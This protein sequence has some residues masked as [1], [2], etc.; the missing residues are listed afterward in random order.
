MAREILFLA[1]P[2]LGDDKPGHQAS[3]EEI[4]SKA[5]QRPIEQVVILGD[6][7][8]DGKVREDYFDYARRQIARF[9]KPVLCI[10]GNHEEG[11][12][13]SRKAWDPQVKPEYLPRFARYF[14]A[15]PWTTQVGD[16]R[17]IGID[18]QILGSGFPEEKHQENWLVKQ[19]Q[20][21][22]AESVKSMVV[23]HTPLFVDAPDASDDPHDYWA[24]PHADR[25]AMLDILTK[26]GVDLLLA[27]HVHRHI[28]PACSFGRFMTLASS[29]FQAHTIWSVKNDRL[30]AGNDDL[31]FYTL[32]VDSPDL[33]LQ[34]H[35]LDHQDRHQ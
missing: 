32:D 18:S 12:N 1:D 28:E 34:R 5:A 25:A 10:P 16:V 9:G 23:M 33:K 7:T 20:Q 4:L 14:N 27:G 22:K 8:Q 13:A 6:V 2:H 35:I 29:S 17:V 3:F 19:L 11:Y 26:H 24:V 30:P 21:A 15:M 31:C